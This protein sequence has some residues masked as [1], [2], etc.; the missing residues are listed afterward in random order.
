M[1]KTEKSVV[2]DAPARRSARPWP[3]HGLAAI[4]WLVAVAIIG[5]FCWIV[6]DLIWHGWPLIDWTFLTTSP[7]LGGREGGI[8]PVIVSTLLILGIALMVAVPLGGSTAILLAEF[9]RRSGWY[10][11]LVGR[12]LDVMAAVPSIVFGLFGNALFCQ[13]LGMGYSILAGGLTLA[14]MVLPILIR[15]MESSIRL[16]PPNYRQAA[17]ALGLSR[18]RTVL[19]VLL[20]QAL[21]GLLVGLVLGIGRVLAET[22]ALLF[23]SGYVMRMPGSLLDSGRALSIHIYDLSMHVPGGESKAYATALV[24][25]VILLVVNAIAIFIADRWQRRLTAKMI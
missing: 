14:L 23:T 17:A 18:T 5:L 16:V 6:G 24:L 13:M 3:D 25:L 2:L 15:T 11:R 7:R 10:G 12:S 20:P 8:L 4:S 19:S 21:P 1:T 9:T 22:A